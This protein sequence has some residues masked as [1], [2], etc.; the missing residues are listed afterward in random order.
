M[1]TF[2]IKSVSEKNTLNISKLFALKHNLETVKFTHVNFGLASKEVNINIVNDMDDNTIELSDHIIKDLKIPTFTSYQIKN[3]KNRLVIGPVIG[4]VLGKSKKVL[5]RKL[6]T[7]NS[8][9]NLY[10]GL[11]GLIV[12]FTLEDLNRRKLTVNGL[13]YNP[14]IGIWERMEV[15]YPQSILKRGL[16]PKKDREYINSI[17]GDRFFNYKKVDKWEIQER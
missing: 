6:R 8:Y 14:E 3:E 4:V 11:K 12:G 1:A 17:Y 13:V 2:H 16:V 7:L 15:P 9:V 5:Y 10:D